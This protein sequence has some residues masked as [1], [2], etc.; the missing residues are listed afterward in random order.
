MNLN[1]SNI[2]SRFSQISGITG[3]DLSSCREFISHGKYMTEKLIVKTPSDEEITACEYCA[4]C[5]ANYSF[6]CAL[7]SKPKQYVTPNGLYSSAKPD[8]SLLSSA[9]LLKEQALAS[10]SN[11]TDDCGFV[12]TG[13]GE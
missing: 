11:L 9:R 10:I 2:T 4:A 1:L 13:V 5:F 12:F 7:L 3:D 6:V 8:S